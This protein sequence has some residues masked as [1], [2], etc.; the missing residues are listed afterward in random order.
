MFEDIMSRQDVAAEL[1]VTTRTVD[2][3]IK[4]GQLKAYK[5]GRQ[6]RIK[7]ED[8]DAAFTPVRDAA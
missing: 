1:S 4:T 2:R 5:I 7:R 8:L 3:W 6:V